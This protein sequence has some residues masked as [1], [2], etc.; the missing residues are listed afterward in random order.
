MIS[1]QIPILNQEINEKKEEKPLENLFIFPLL[2]IL[3][4]NKLHS[5]RN[6][7]KHKCPKA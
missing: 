5:T 7:T 6:I 1:L 2:R 4:K 3:K